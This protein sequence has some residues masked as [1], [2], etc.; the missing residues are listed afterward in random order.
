MNDLLLS[1]G[2]K[3]ELPSPPR[4]YAE[5]YPILPPL[6]PHEYS[7]GPLYPTLPTAE[8]PVAPIPHRLPS[9]HV[10]SYGQFQHSSGAVRYSKTMAPPTIGK[11]EPRV[12]TYRSVERLFRAKGPVSYTREPESMDDESTAISYS[13]SI[14]STSLDMPAPLA[15]SSSK[16]DSAGPIKL[17]P[18]L[19]GPVSL[20]EE[21]LPPMTLAPLGSTTR[22]TLPPIHDL[23]ADSLVSRSDTTS[24][25]CSPKTSR[26]LSSSS[27]VSTGPSGTCSPAS[28]SIGAGGVAV[29]RLVHQVKR[30]KVRNSGIEMDGE[31]SLSP[32]GSQAV[33]EDEEQSE[34][35][36]EALRRTRAETIKALIILLNSNFR[37]GRRA[38]LASR[39]VVAA[40]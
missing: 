8:R 22:T 1:L 10:E 33:S 38:T 21:L 18:I 30:M 4:H 13:S 25:L 14:R 15:S 34:E 29:E 6:P 37:V 35:D 17:A 39:P 27:E 32:D 12:S 24:T 3:M 23:I 31:M 19:S 9:P 11:I 16:V 2:E 26:T 20:D 7:Y 28:A 40:V 5:S 36:D